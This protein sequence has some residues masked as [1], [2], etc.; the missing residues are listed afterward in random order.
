MSERPLLPFNSNVQFQSSGIVLERATWRARLGDFDH[1]PTEAGFSSLLCAVGFARA[2]P[3]EAALADT[4][5]LFGCRVEKLEI[6]QRCSSSKGFLRSVGRGNRMMP[7]SRI[8]RNAVMPPIPAPATPG[9]SWNMAVVYISLHICPRYKSR[10]TTR[11]FHSNNLSR[12]D[13][14]MPAYQRSC[15]KRIP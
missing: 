8:S 1:T 9:A 13:S 11:T 14:A 12:L 6:C 5:S 2:A 10:C 4:T 7:S 3:R 15:A